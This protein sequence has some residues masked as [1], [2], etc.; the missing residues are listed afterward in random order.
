MTNSRQFRWWAGT[1]ATLMLGACGGG[2]TAPPP[3]PP[4]APAPTVGVGVQQVFANL[5]FMSPVAMLQAPQ[6]NSRWFVV[7]QVG[8]VQVFNNSPAVNGLDPVFIDIASRVTSSG[9]TGLLGMAFHPS[10]PT[11]GRVYLFYSHT[12]TGGALVSRLSEFTTTDGGQTLNSN[13]ERVLLTINKPGNESNHNGGGI[14]FGPGGFLFIGLGDGGGGND[15]HGTIGNGQTLNTLLGKMLRINVEVGAG[16]FLYSVPTDNP[17][18]ANPLCGTNGSG[19]QECP[20]IYAWGFRNPW[21]WS[22]DRQNSELWVGD[23]GQSALEEVDRV[24]R[25][26][27]Y[28]WRCFEGTRNTQLACGNLPDRLPPVAE[29]GR[30]VG[31]TVTGGYVYRGTAIPAFVGQYVFG[32]FG[33]GRIWNIASD[34]QPTLTMTGGFASGLSISSFGEGSDGELYVVSYDGRLFRIIGLIPG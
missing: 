21:R 7:E 18:V 8:R 11:D 23:V 3:A 15:Q 29:Y 24:V 4:P 33:N 32:D 14:A 1:V 22:F 6:D 2:S 20:E 25:G 10:F 5:N 9:E 17:F 31:T 26:G 28:G 19:T 13:T 27:N 16:G 30:S 12:T 34:T